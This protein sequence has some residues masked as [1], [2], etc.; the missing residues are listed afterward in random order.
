MPNYPY[1]FQ[2]PPLNVQDIPNNG[3]VGEFLGISAGGVLDWLPVSAGAGDMLKSENLSGLASYPTARTNLGLGTTSTPTFKNLV[4][5][6][7][8]IATSAP[9]TISQTWNDAAVAF[10][11]F[12]VNAVSTASASGSLLLDLQVGGVSKFNVDKNGYL[13]GV[14]NVTGFGANQLYSASSI[15]VTN[16]LSI[17]STSV[18]N[19]IVE[20]AS[21]NKIVC[22]A[23]T[24]F[25][26][27][28]QAISG[29]NGV[30]LRASMDTILLRDGLPNTLALRNSTAAQTFNVYGTYSTSPSLAYSRLAIACDTSGNATLTTQ[31]TGTAG[32]VSIN[33]VPVGLGK[34]N[35]T[36]NLAI[37]TTALNANTADSYNTVIGYQA[38]RFTTSGY[39]NTFVGARAGTNLT[40]GN[41]NSAF[42]LDSLGTVSTGANN[43]AFGLNALGSIGTTSQN[44]AIGTSAGFLLPVSGYNSA[45]ANSVF[46]G[47]DTRPAADSQTN[48]IVIGHSAVGL[49]SNT[50]VLGNASITTTALRGNVG[51]GT[52]APSSKLHVAGEAFLAVN[53]SNTAPSLRVGSGAYVNGWY[54]FGGVQLNAV[55]NSQNM[56]G[57][58]AAG[59]NIGVGNLSLGNAGD[60]VLE[61]DGEADHLAMRRGATGQTFSVYGTY[62]GAAWERFTITAPTSGNVLL[63]TYKGTGGIA[64]GLELQTDGVTRMTIA[65]N[66]IVTIPVSIVVNSAVR[67]GFINNLSNSLSMFSFVD[68][69]TGTSTYAAAASAPLMRFGGT[70]DSFP[71]IARD[72]AGI[73]FTG[74]AGGL[75]S[76]IKVPAVAVSALP[77]AATAGVGARAFV[78]DATAPVF[79]SAVTGG[80]AVAVPVYS[81]G[82]AWY[83]G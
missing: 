68:D 53:G 49:G 62:P 27:G 63:G 76:H 35:F 25:G 81:T 14:A 2:L 22:N 28:S 71:A 56:F 4:I 16:I 83:V 6:T 54:S 74:A 59:T 78:N 65:T 30:A 34:G 69:S 60:V 43:S 41:S 51:I 40:T 13:Y 75:T 7:G 15:A 10:T 19:F 1:S 80:G 57:I 17:G 70:T 50:V 73:K 58:N 46:I 52:T 82:S 39:F 8:S 33:G 5:S 37:G 67:T 12:K 61:R 55:V 21:E 48:Q 23:G 45:S 44:T 31:S 72:G 24:Q 3:A 38:G 20:L 9:V 64:R 29:G 66:G 18:T 47:Y 36:T 32:T 42:G 77:L 11:A 26:W 79:G